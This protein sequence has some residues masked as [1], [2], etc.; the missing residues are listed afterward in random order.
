MEPFGAPQ[1]FN[2]ES[3]VCLGTKWIQQGNLKQ[4]RG[5]IILLEN[6]FG[7]QR[8]D[9]LAIRNIFVPHS[10]QH[11]SKL[12]KLSSLKSPNWFFKFF[13][14]SRDFPVYSSSYYGFRTDCF[15]DFHFVTKLV[16]E[17]PTNLFFL[18]YRFL[19][20]ATYLMALNVLYNYFLLQWD[21][22]VIKAISIVM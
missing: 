16:F 2:F 14:T 20:F 19:K 6:S 4:G 17:G 8:E 13:N 7:I 15:N 3:W 5:R 18:K 1:K 9:N 21:K 10:K 22:K 12:V 11:T